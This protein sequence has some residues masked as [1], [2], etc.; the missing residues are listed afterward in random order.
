MTG[1][2]DDLLDLARLESG[3]IELD[4]EHVAPETLIASGIE[5][6]RPH[7]E[8]ARLR[9]EID[10]ADGTARCAHGQGSIEQILLNLV[11]NAIKFTD[12]GGWIRV[13]AFASGST[14]A[15]SV[16]DS[17]VGIAPEEL[18]RVFERFYKSDKARRSGGT[19]LGLA[20]AKH[21]V[22]AH[23]GTT[24]DS[25]LGTGSTFTFRLPLADLP[26]DGTNL[27]FAMVG[28]NVDD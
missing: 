12:S 7:L 17:G 22:M 9:F 15:I 27:L 21:I 23:G 20:I 6:L 26:P 14:I 8:R 2:V 25:K 4:L 28:P 18:D 1:I 13:S 11:H 5:R 3:R 24:A 16:A 19:G 10:V